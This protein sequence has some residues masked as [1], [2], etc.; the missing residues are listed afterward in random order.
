VTWYFPLKNRYIRNGKLTS[1]QTSYSIDSFL[2][3]LTLFSSIY[4]SPIRALKIPLLGTYADELVTIL[5]LL[6]ILLLKGSKIGSRQK[7]I[8]L[9]LSF[10][11]LIGF[12][13]SAIN[14]NDA[15]LQVQISQGVLWLKMWIV[16][17]FIWRS[18][19]TSDEII[20]TSLLFL[21]I[22]LYLS[23]VSVFFQ[24]TIPSWRIY[25]NFLYS[26]N[27]YFFESFSGY[28][29][30]PTIL[31]VLS[32]ITVIVFL[33][34]KYQYLFITKMDIYL[35]VL[36]TLGS[37]RRRVIIALFLC[38]VFILISRSLQTSISRATLVFSTL[39]SLFIF[40]S[41]LFYNLFQS[42]INSY[43]F[44]AG[45]SARSLLYQYGLLIALELAPLGGGFATFGTLGA[46]YNYSTYY[47][48]FGFNAIYGLSGKY[49]DYSTDT[50]WPAVL[51]ETGFLGL[52]IFLLSIF[53]G[54]VASKKEIS[55]HGNSNLYNVIIA[56]TLFTLIDSMAAQ[57][58]LSQPVAFLFGIFFA[59][60]SNYRS[61]NI[62]ACTGQRVV[63]K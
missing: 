46:S 20:I 32:G 11:L 33:V 40:T 19:I 9:L 16:V 31:G 56:L 25:F 24:L 13:S 50:F 41:P 45:D 8:L 14:S 54:L 51:G 44:G 27:R 53:L 10:F 28:T 7:F 37:G 12:L 48:D 38:V 63:K 60:S 21:K 34:F 42:L 59:L 52:F 30:H 4:D 43:S 61:Q 26:D 6:R 15:S 57:T 29:S 36:L 62:L 18:K 5:L 47:L 2:L 39:L 23:L 35:A 22:S 58:Y 3:F 1:F 49:D 55:L 17:W